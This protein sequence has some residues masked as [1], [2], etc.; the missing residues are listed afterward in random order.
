MEKRKSQPY[1]INYYTIYTIIFVAL[2]IG[3]MFAFL[4]YGKSFLWASDGLSQHYPNLEYTREWVRTVVKNIIYK[5]E[6]NIPMWSLSIGLGQDFQDALLVRPF[7]LL[8]A[9]FPE[10]TIEQ[11]LVIR[12]IIN[13]YLAGISYSLFVRYFHMKDYACLVGSMLYTF[14]GFSIYFACRHTFFLDLLI[15]FPLMLLGVEKI[16]NKEKP[17][18]FLCM[19]SAI[20]IS[21]Y[22]FLYMLIIPVFIY[23]CIRYFNMNRTKSIKDFLK[24]LLYTTLI[25]VWGIGLAA[26][27]FVPGVIRFMQSARTEKVSIGSYLHFDWQY[28]YQLLTGFLSMNKIGLH[29]FMGF[30][31]IAFVCAVLLF[32][33]KGK[34]LKQLKIGLGICILI[35]CVP[36]FVLVFSGFVG[37]TNRWTFIMAFTIALI[38]TVMIPQLFTL[39]EQEKKYLKIITFIYVLLEVILHLIVGERLEYTYISLG[40]L[41]VMFVTDGKYVQKHPYRTELLVVLVTLVDISLLSWSFY[42]TT[43]NNYIKE[44]VNA[45]TVEAEKDNSAI[46]IMNNNSDSSVYRTDVIFGSRSSKWRY[47]NY[48]LRSGING[49]SS[50]YSLITDPVVKYVNDVGDSQHSI[51]FQIL[52]FDQRTVL[53]ELAAVKYITVAESEIPQVPYGYIGEQMQEKTYLNGDKEN[54]YLYVNQ[55][56]LPIMY[57][58]DSYILNE[59]YN[60]YSVNEKEQAMLQGIVLEHTLEGYDQTKISFNDKTVAGKDEILKQIQSMDDLKNIEIYDG[61]ILVKKNNAKVTIRFNGWSNS[62]TYVIWEDLLYTGL[63][64]AEREQYN[65]KD[66]ATVYDKQSYRSANVLQE[67][68]T[69]SYI[70]ISTEGVNK[71][72]ELLALDHQYY[73]G[74]K[75]VLMNMGYAKTSKSSVTLKFSKAGYYSFN[76]LR[77]VCQPMGKYVEQVSKLVEDPVEEIKI[78]GNIITAH[79]VL[80]EDKILCIAVPYNTGWKAEINGKPVKILEGNGMYMAIPLKK[81]ANTIKLY[82]QSPGLLLGTAISLL[83]LGILLLV[84]SVP[85]LRQTIRQIV[86]KS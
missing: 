29:G 28:Y 79:T 54:I 15:G 14:S 76:D 16:L 84:W 85:K 51:P 69:S 64:K 59:Q 82:Y 35:F 12:V 19:T 78:D 41:V 39:T 43:G 73:C 71:E 30:A 33:R 7:D 81:G 86:K 83:S 23:A 11:F 65:L 68:P 40:I 44:F 2:F 77:I 20:G 21:S 46:E 6:L 38:A 26:C 31:S 62:E 5:H 49:V 74:E 70:S 80:S 61:G 58:Y 10:H 48:G 66:G 63:S 72:T 24:C 53:D 3:V 32:S 75:D 37:K 60:G 18:L 9:F 42:S 1:L 25:F 47:K 17:W 56:Y 4:Y 50:Y 57:T 36:A 13:L 52:D 34:K 22:V 8:Y 27:A 55:Y 67:V 45:G